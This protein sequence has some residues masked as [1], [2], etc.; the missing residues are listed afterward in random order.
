MSTKTS[1]QSFFKSGPAKRSSK[2]KIAP[3]A[4]DQQMLPL[5]LRL[6]QPQLDGLNI[7]RQKTGLRQNELVRRA[8][9]EF[10]RKELA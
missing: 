1:T 2:T 5:S 4:L 3:A 10:L 7:L 6:T 9:D 8:I